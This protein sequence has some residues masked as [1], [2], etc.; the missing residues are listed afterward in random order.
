[1]RISEPKRSGYD[2]ILCGLRSDIRPAFNQSPAP[3]P[4]PK[5]G[6]LVNNAIDL[7]VQKRPQSLTLPFENRERESHLVSEE[8]FERIVREAEAGSLVPPLP[9]HLTHD[10]SFSGLRRSISSVRNNHFSMMTARRRPMSVEIGNMSGHSAAEQLPVS[11][12]RHST[13]T[14]LPRPPTKNGLA[15]EL[16]DRTRSC[17]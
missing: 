3:P 7:S 1:M 2:G 10:T 14:A 9:H 17:G 16:V 6:N 12:S 13:L 4:P 8:E 11:I 15:S 5:D